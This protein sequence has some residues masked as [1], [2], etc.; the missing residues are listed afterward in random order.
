[1]RKFLILF[2]F[3]PTIAFSQNYNDVLDSMIIL[4]NEFNNFFKLPEDQQDFSKYQDVRHRLESY[5]EQKFF[6]KLDTFTILV[7]QGDTNLMKKYIKYIN[8]AKGSSS[9]ANVNVLASM[10]INYPNVLFRSTNTN[11][12]SLFYGLAMGLFNIY[13]GDKEVWIYLDKLF[14]NISKSSQDSL[15]KYLPEFNERY[16][17]K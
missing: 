6:A 7:A 17:P 11:R 16:N 5:Y 10:F 14:Y 2:V 4:Q 3:L 8:S 12:Y 9:E 15:I 13:C 1:M